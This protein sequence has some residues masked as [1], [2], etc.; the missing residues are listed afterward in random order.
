ME[1]LNKIKKKG[2]YDKNKNNEVN[3]HKKRNTYKRSRAHA[4]WRT[5]RYVMGHSYT[6][7]RTSI[8]LYITVKSCQ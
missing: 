5:C 3:T 6:E 2:I 4:Q 7:E 8:T 1:F